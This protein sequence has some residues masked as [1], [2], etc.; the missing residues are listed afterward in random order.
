MIINASVKSKRT[1]LLIESYLKL[2]NSGVDPENI[3]VLVQNSKKKKDFIEQI[4]KHSKNGSIG[5]IKIYSFWGLAYNF[6]QDNWAIVENSIK[7]IKNPKISPNLCGLEVSQHLFK[8][9][10]KEVDF[11]G[12]NSKTSLL[13]QLLR[14]YSLITLND[15]SDEE[16]D[17]EPKFYLKVSALKQKKRF[18]N[19]SIKQLTR[20]HLTTFARLIFLNFFMK[21]LKIL[22]N[23]FF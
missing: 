23:T 2:L 8:E 15:L 3:L 14:R 4:K 21:K 11:T 16:V 10:I 6:V 19:T 22:L 18:Q 5:N 20:E 7:D 1:K 13:H 9:C 12:Y 17:F